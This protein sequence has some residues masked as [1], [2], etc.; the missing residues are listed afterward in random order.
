MIYVY[1]LFLNRR[2]KLSSDQDEWLRSWKWWCEVGSTW[3]Q[4]G[5][6]SIQNKIIGNLIHIKYNSCCYYFMIILQV[7]TKYSKILGA[8]AGDWVDVFSLDDDSLQIIPQPIHAVILLFPISEGVSWVNP[9][10]KKNSNYVQICHVVLREKIRA[11]LIIHH[12]LFL[13]RH[14]YQRAR[15]NLGWEGTR[16]EQESILH[17]AKG[18]QRLWHCGNH[19]FPC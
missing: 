7:L 6:K 15:S 11:K 4:S 13:V 17:E 5:G 9:I 16:S 1:Y 14:I 8:K 10:I 3:I 19:A 12:V 2:K 18:R